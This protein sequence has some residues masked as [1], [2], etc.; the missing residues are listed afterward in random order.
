MTSW[1]NVDPANPT[2]L[3]PATV[4]NSDTTSFVAPAINHA[5]RQ[6]VTLR[7]YGGDNS[8]SRSVATTYPLYSRAKSGSFI[9][10][11]VDRDGEGDAGT[12]TLTLGG[13]EQGAAISIGLRPLLAGVPTVRAG[14]PFST[15]LSSGNVT[16]PADVASGD[17]AYA[18]IAVR[19]ISN[20]TSLPAGWT[21]VAN[22]ATTH[23][24]GYHVYTRVFKKD[25][26][27]SGSEDST[28]VAVSGIDG[29]ACGFLFTV[30]GASSFGSIVSATDTTAL[31]FTGPTGTDA[32]GVLLMCDHHCQS[33]ALDSR[34][35]DDDFL[36]E[37]VV[38]NLIFAGAFSRLSLHVMPYDA[39]GPATLTVATSDY[40][41]AFSWIAYA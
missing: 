10:A 23:P 22:L 14:T 34:V 39:T 31:S 21:S 36:T 1:S 35:N 32:Y 19:W 2:N 27:C 20:A 25:S 38:T 5:L 33:P 28:T 4:Y 41:N 26:A 15:S 3:P 9:V 37:Q 24:S 40:A 12:S 8:P 29:Y 7:M 6:N 13:G 11:G 17:E 18:V 16:F 30:R